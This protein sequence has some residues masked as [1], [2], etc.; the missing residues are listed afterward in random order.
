MYIIYL[1]K[2]KTVLP[3][4]MQI[5]LKTIKD[6]SDE[7]KENISL[8]KENE[9]NKESLVF[10]NKPPRYLIVYK[11]NYYQME[12]NNTKSLFKF[13]WKSYITIN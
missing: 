8:V 1:F 10:R 12:R 4:E 9:N 5:N 3:R 7:S 2:S 13:W 6:S 11:S